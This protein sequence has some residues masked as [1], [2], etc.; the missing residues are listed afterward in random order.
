MAFPISVASMWAASSLKDDMDA[1][2]D[3]HGV[4]G[5]VYGVDCPLTLVVYSNSDRLSVVLPRGDSGAE[6]ASG[7]VS[8][9]ISVLSSVVNVGDEGAV[10]DSDER[11]PNQLNTRDSTSMSGSLGGSKVEDARSSDEMPWP[12]RESLSP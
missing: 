1:F 4:P 11:G 9:G 6:P 2:A 7:V 3:M 8:G 12:V 5:V 10:R